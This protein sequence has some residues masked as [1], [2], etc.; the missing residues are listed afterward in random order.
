MVGIPYN[1]HLSLQFGDTPLMC[2]SHK[3]LVEY[4]RLLLDRGAGV[5]MQDEVSE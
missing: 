3:G 5:N 1:M 2:A 4:V